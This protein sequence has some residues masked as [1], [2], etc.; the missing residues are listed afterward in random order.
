MLP[1]DNRGAF[2][3]ALHFLDGEVD[4]AVHRFG[5]LLSYP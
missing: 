3:C 2:H 5:H 4:A 1:H